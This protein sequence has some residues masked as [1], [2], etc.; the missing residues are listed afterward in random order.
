MSSLYEEK[1]SIKLL[2][3][4][5][6]ELLN[7]ACCESKIN[8][9]GCTVID[10]MFV[11]GVIFTRVRNTSK[12]NVIIEIPAVETIKWLY[13]Q[14]YFPRVPAHITLKNVKLFEAENVVRMYFI[15]KKL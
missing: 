5:Y 4:D 1:L 9:D 11:L 10:I 7:E 3:R 2:T 12:E 8:F 13:E 15:R 6:L 14:D